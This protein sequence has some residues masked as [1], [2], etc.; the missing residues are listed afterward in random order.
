MQFFALHFALILIFQV[1][2]IL[3]VQNLRKK[4]QAYHVSKPVLDILTNP[5]FLEQAAVPTLPNYKNA[6][7]HF[8][9]FLPDVLPNRYVW[10][11]SFSPTHLP[12]L[13]LVSF[14]YSRSSKFYYKHVFVKNICKIL[15]IVKQ[16]SPYIKFIFFTKTFC[17][18]FNKLLTICEKCI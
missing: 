9:D 18:L 5:N 1:P 12:D 7:H 4:F 6:R 17:F 3:R 11:F 2:A 8:P 14:P 15:F 16:R 10:G 13:V